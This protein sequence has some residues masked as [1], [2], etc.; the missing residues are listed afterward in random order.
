MFSGVLGRNYRAGYLL[1]Y[2]LRCS[3]QMLLR[4]LL[5]LLVRSDLRVEPAAHVHVHLALPR[6]RRDG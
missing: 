2:L 4:L 1:R 6:W 5:L 3:R